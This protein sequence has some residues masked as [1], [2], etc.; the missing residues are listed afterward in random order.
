MAQR[1]R[2]RAPSAGGLGLNPDQE[3]KSHT[4]Q[5]RVLM[6][7]QRSKILSAAAT[8]QPSQTNKKIFLKK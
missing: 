3:T 7:K 8:T 2:L 5:L 1:L 6:Q 4:R